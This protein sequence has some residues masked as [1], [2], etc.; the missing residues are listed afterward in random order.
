MASKHRLPENQI[1]ISENS[2]FLSSKLPKKP[3]PADTTNNVTAANRRI[4][5]TI[6]SIALIN[7]PPNK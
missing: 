2:R 3:L 5:V 1:E 7:L 4:S 6:I